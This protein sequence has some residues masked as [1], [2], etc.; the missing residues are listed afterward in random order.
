MTIDNPL[1]LL[2]ILAIGIWVI[3]RS[4]KTLT[5]KDLHI[6]EAEELALQDSLAKGEN[7]NEAVKSARDQAKFFWPFLHVVVWWKGIILGSIISIFALVGLFIT[8]VTGKSFWSLIGNI[9][10]FVAE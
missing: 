2:L 7:S 9:I 3:M 6:K 1:I 5:I 8:L 4:W 10:K